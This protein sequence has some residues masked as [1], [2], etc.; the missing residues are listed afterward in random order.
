MIWR[1][2]EMAL[3]CTAANPIRD[4]EVPLPSYHSHLNSAFHKQATNII[5]ISDMKEKAAIFPLFSSL[6]TELRLQIWA[7]AARLYPPR[8]LELHLMTKSS[9]NASS[10]SATSDVSLTEQAH[11]LSLSPK[12]ERYS[13]V[14]AIFSV[15]HEARQE[16]LNVY[17]PGPG[18]RL[19]A[20]EGHRQ[21]WFCPLRETVYRTQSFLVVDPYEVGQ[22]SVRL[23]GREV[24]R[25]TVPF[26]PLPG[27]GFVLVTSM[28][29]RLSLISSPNLPPSFNPLS[30]QPFQRRDSGKWDCT[31]CPSASGGIPAARGDELLRIARRKHHLARSDIPLEKLTPLHG[32]EETVFWL[33]ALEMARGFQEREGIF[34]GSLGDGLNPEMAKA[35]VTG[36]EMVG[37]VG[38]GDME[39]WERQVMIV[40]RFG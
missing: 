36:L 38:D 4:H 5:S 31:P 30:P 9:P 6:P 27:E 15:S 33:H 35:V 39:A 26:W 37:D 8:V 3:S 40:T 28:A 23:A 17:S 18:L 32:F 34:R 29:K 1:S 22:G 12:A 13:G 10:S 2:R 7:Q 11:V 20:D 16:A 25:Q 21:A 14:P 19:S 24:P